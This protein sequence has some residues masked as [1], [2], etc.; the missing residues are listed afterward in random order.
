MK[1]LCV[2]L[3]ACFLCVCLSVACAE[4]I[5][6]TSY[7]ID[8]LTSMYSHI[9]AEIKARSFR[10]AKQP[11]NPGTDEILFRKIPWGSTPNDFSSI[12]GI[13]SLRGPSEASC[14]SWEWKGND[15]GTSL[16][17]LSDSGVKIYGF[18]DDFAVA[19]IP[20]S[21]VYAYF[22]YDIG[23]DEKP[24]KDENEAKLYKAEYSFK[25]VDM[26]A[27]F[28]LLLGKMEN[29]YGTP[30][31]N[32]NV[33]NVWNL[34]GNDYEQHDEWYVWYG[35]NN[36]GVYLRTQY[37]IDS[38]DKTTSHTELELVY[39]RTNSAEMISALEAAFAKEELEEMLNNDNN[40]GL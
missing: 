21:S 36:T 15:I 19:G 12:V 4:T 18:P 34:S 13:S 27:A 16:H 7:S 35:E 6:Y 14:Y 22:L 24:L 29:L 9:F 40:D 23:D 1:H 2:I 28:E 39:G 37:R 20:I 30:K 31:K 8:E 38:V 32:E 3:I 25:A 33:T 17:S 5:D 11:P 10:E 26:A